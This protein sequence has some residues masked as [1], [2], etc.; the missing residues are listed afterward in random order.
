MATITW[1]GGASG[2]W[3]AQLN[4]SGFVVPGAT[5]DVVIST[6]TVTVD[7]SFATAGVD[8]T[9]GAVLDVTGTLALGGVLQGPVVVAGTL[10]G[11][12]VEGQVTL[13]GTGTL[14]DVTQIPVVG[15]PTL[16]PETAAGEPQPIVVTAELTL[17]QGL[18]PTETFA[19]DAAGMPAVEFGPGVVT[20]GPAATVTLSETTSGRGSPPAAGAFFYGTLVNQGL[21]TG[22]FGAGDLTFADGSFTNSGTV[23][24]TPITLEQSTS[25]VANFQHL[26]LFWEQTFGPTLDATTGQFSNAGLLAMTGGTLLLNAP[27]VGNQGRIL[28]TDAPSQLGIVNSNTAFVVD[29][30]LSTEIVV[31]SGVTSFANS[32]TLSADTVEFLG[33]VALAGL[34]SIAAAQQLAFAGALDLGGGTLD[35]SRFGSVFI[36]GAVKDG[37]LQPGSGTLFVEGATLDDV[38]LLPGAHVT[39][40]ITLVDPPAGTTALTLDTVTTELAYSAGASIAGVAITSVGTADTLAL[41]GGTVTLGATSSFTLAAGTFDAIGPGALEVDGSLVISDG[42]FGF[43]GTLVGTGHASVA[44]GATLGASSLAGALSITVGP[45]AVL[46]AAALGGSPNIT[47]DAGASATFDALSGSPTIDFAGGPA[48]LVLPDTGRLAVTL[49]NLGPGDLV[50]FTAVSSK[51]NGIFGNGAATVGGGLLLVTGASGDTASAPVQNPSP[52]LSFMVTNDLVGGTLV[53]VACF[54]EGTHIATARGPVPVERLRR[55]ELVRTAAGRLRPAIWIGRRR[56]VCRRQARPEAVWPV[57]I[58]AHAFGPGRPA[59]DLWLSPDHA[60]A[61]RGALIPVRYLINGATIVQEPRRCGSGA[62]ADAHRWSP[63]ARVWR[64]RAR[65][66]C[67]A[68]GRSG[69]A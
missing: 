35:A 7:G 38:T 50:D 42:F 19:L 30:L 23:N 54:R 17:L 31:G 18:Y 1:R 12:T 29:T 3:S 10:V 25:Y 24:L 53:T 16:T 55:G 64:R 20:L 28:L 21:I 27:T 33:S 9:G 65:R 26:T 58:A 60:V 48:L 13:E 62:R 2:D 69:T 51:P 36:E 56:V 4:W 39:G 40:P 6:A 46:G 41:L 44:P 11:G 8:L 49:Q 52:N 14:I 63:P 47:L 67:G 66:C 61:F 68:P 37:V 5:D 32:G 59:R 57:R 45:N 43:T 22:S 34:G 15:G